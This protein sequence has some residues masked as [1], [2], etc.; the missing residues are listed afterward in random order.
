MK[1]SHQ[2]AD[3]S[4]PGRSIQM[5]GA[6]RTSYAWL[7][8]FSH[9]LRNFAAHPVTRQI[10]DSE[11]FSSLL[12][13]DNELWPCDRLSSGGEARGRSSASM[14]ARAGTGPIGRAA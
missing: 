14:D 8:W 7:S 2:L 6:S 11:R 4:P 9:A 13:G 3:L 5:H 10:L 12:F 1:V